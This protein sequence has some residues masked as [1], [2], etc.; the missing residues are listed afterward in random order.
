MDGWREVGV[1]GTVYVHA[2]ER[3]FISKA[4]MPLGPVL[5]RVCGAVASL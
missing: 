4:A 2:R 1:C 3:W 5:T